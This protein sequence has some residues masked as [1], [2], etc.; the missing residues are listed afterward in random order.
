MGRGQK[1]IEKTHCWVLPCPA[2]P[3]FLLPFFTHPSVELAFIL[4]GGVVV[5]SLAPALLRGRPGEED[6][7]GLS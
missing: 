1:E 3:L 4:L 5:K 6:P 2:T 7:S